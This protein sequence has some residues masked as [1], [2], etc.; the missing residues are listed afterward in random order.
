LKKKIQFLAPTNPDQSNIQAPERHFSECIPKH[1][2]VNFLSILNNKSTLFSRR[3]INEIVNDL[4]ELTQDSLNGTPAQT[5]TGFSTLPARTSKHIEWSPMCASSPPD[6]GSTWDYREVPKT[7]M[8]VSANEEVQ[9]ILEHRP[10]QLPKMNR[11]VTSAPTSPVPR[12]K[13]LLNNQNNFL[14]FQ[15]T[16]L[17]SGNHLHSFEIKRLSAKS[18]ESITTTLQQ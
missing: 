10:R 15:H 5:P 3:S 14:S 13:K 8:T 2:Q 4:N 12:S 1:Q 18:L 17:P 11:S 6:S 7:P 16:I 9:Q